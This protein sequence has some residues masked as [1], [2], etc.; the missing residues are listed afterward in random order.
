M[1][2]LVAAA[3]TFVDY[4]FL[5]TVRVSPSWPGWGGV[6]GGIFSADAGAGARCQDEPGS[7]EAVHTRVATRWFDLCRRNAG[8]YVKLGQQVATMNHVLPPEYV[9]LF[10]QL[11]DRAP[12]FPYADVAALFQAECGRPVGEVGGGCAV[13][14]VPLP[15]VWAP[16]YGGRR[17]RCLLSLPRSPWPRRPSRRHGGRAG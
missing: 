4:K 14:F 12:T 6:V 7:L 9:A 8:L 15:P 5:L 13:G 1:R 11:H 17:C 2:A 3:A 16:A 10:S